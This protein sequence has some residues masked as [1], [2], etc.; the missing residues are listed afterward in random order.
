[1]ALTGTF[2]RADTETLRRQINVLNEN[3][4][5]EAVQI[6]L[7]LGAR[8]LHLAERQG[9]SLEKISEMRELISLAKTNSKC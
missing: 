5:S 7:Q 8:S 3:V 1:M 9:A 4:S 2:S 6:F